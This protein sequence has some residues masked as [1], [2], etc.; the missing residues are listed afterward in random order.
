MKKTYPLVANGKH[1]DRLLEATKHDIRKYVKRCRRA[2]L[3]EG[4]DYWDFDC[5]IG[6]DIDNA[7]TAHLSELIGLVDAAAKE[8]KASIFVEVNPKNGHRVHD[9]RAPTAQPELEAE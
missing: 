1:P 7:N 4:V 6:V 5:K 9:G 2:P 8:G 3:P